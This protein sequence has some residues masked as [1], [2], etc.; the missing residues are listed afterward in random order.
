[1]QIHAIAHRSFELSQ[2][3][4]KK[5]ILESDVEW[6]M[7]KKLV[8]LKANQNDVRKSIPKGL[9]Y[10]W[11]NFGVANGMA[12]VIEDA[13]RFPSNFAQEVIGGMLNLDVNKWR[14]PRKEN[15]PDKKIKYL[16]ESLKE[17]F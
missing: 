16:K 2:F 10:F 5:A 13:E 14:K 9:S 17:C 6:A 1:M 3:Y 12:H 15:Y 11:V 4:F 7:N 8:D